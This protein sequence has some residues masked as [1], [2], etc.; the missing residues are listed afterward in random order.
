M[1]TETLEQVKNA[2]NA[3]PKPKV[4]PGDRVWYWR[5]TSD[6]PGG[7]KRLEPMPADLLRPS[8]LDASQWELNLLIRG[9]PPH[10]KVGVPYSDVPV[11]GCF[12]IRDAAMLDAVK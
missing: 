5:E 6:L 11:S 12:T 10:G 2:K 3:K 9:A 4:L 8:K 7:P 1:A